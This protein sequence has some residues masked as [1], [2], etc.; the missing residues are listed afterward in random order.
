MS[1]LGMCA[2]RTPEKSWVPAPPLPL[3]LPA[4]VHG[5]TQPGGDFGSWI[6][7]THGEALDVVLES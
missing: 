5:V 7:T 4:N 6:P 1:L 2:F 3:Q